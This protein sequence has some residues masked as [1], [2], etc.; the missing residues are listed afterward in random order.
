MGF[1]NRTKSFNWIIKLFKITDEQSVNEFK[2]EESILKSVELITNQ[3]NL[4]P[5]HLDV[6]FTEVRNKLND[7]K[8]VIAKQE[9]I[10]DSMICF[11]T[12]RDN[13]HFS[14]T[15]QILNYTEKPQN[16]F[17]EISIQITD[18]K[19]NR[20]DAERIAEKLIIDYEFEYAYITRLPSDYS[21]S[22]ERKMKQGLFSKKMEILKTDHIWPSH[23]VAINDSYIKK[24]YRINYLN[25]SQIT[26]LKRNSIF[27]E[28][29]IVKAISSKITKWSLNEQELEHVLADKKIK[30]ISILTPELGF[31][32][33]DKAKEYENLMK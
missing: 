30:E 9:E 26:A 25:I 13:T 33:T 15:N 11:G 4:I 1:F 22:T 8:K 16:S 19:I 14:I 24:P 17:I 2:T 10:Y 31:L 21:I 6:N 28:Y 29:G 32:N 7:F 12:D 20:P 5:T 23:L 18:K 3:T 27:S